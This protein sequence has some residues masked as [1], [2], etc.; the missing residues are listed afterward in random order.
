M[1]VINWIYFESIVN[2]IKHTF[3]ILFSTSGTFYAVI[4]KFD[5]IEIPPDVRLLD[6][7]ENALR[8]K[9]FVQPFYEY[10]LLKKNE[11]SIISNE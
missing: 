1:S 2:L 8:V 10:L 11:I 5:Y 9:D 4:K 7:L 6:D 3:V